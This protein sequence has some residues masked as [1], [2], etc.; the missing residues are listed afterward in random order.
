MAGRVGKDG[1]Y[2][3]RRRRSKRKHNPEIRRQQEALIAK[4]GMSSGNTSFF[5]MRPSGS[6]FA[7][8]SLK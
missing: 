5:T 1:D 8:G 4:Y 6:S 3:K 2:M 7:K